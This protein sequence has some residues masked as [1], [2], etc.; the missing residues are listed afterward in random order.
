MAIFKFNEGEIDLPSTWADK[1]VNVFTVGS[2]LPLALSVVISREPIDSKKD[3]ATYADEKLD[4]ISHQL[5][6]FKIIEKR[7]IEVAGNTALDADFTWRG[8]AGLMYQRQTYVRA[9]KTLLVFT[10]TARRELQEEYRAQVDAV[11]SSLRLTD[12]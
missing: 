8:Q 5:K 10:V 1:T 12:S 9:G 6:E 4:D 2:S 3:L 11:L 7:Q